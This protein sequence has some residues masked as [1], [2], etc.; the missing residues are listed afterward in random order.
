MKDKAQTKYLWGPEIIAD[1][2]VIISRMERPVM[3]DG[4][5]QSLHGLVFGGVRGHYYV[6][7]EEAMRQNLIH[8]IDARTEV[9]SIKRMLAGRVDVTSVPVSTLNYFMNSMPI[10]GQIFVSPKLL[11]SYSRHLMLTKGM[12]E[13]HEQLKKQVLA[14]AGNKNWQA[15]LKKYGL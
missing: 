6:G 1:S 8:R 5:A 15:I 11:F 12:V 4:T 7:L 10:S 3:F 2:N 9:V 14:L 13:E